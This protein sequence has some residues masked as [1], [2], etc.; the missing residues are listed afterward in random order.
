MLPAKIGPWP[1]VK[2]LSMGAVSEVYLVRDS[3]DP[4]VYRV[5]KRILP[6][7]TERLDL[8]EAF[9]REARLSRAFNHPNLVPIHASDMDCDAPYVVMEFVE[10]C[11]L[12]Q[13]MSNREGA[14]P[15]EIAVRVACDVAE[16]LEH[17]HGLRDEAGARLVVA[18]RDVTPRN[19]MLPRTGEAVLIDFGLVTGAIAKRMTATD[20]VKGTWRYAAPEQLKGQDVGP[21]TDVYGLAA[22]FSY[23][24]TGARPFSDCSGLDEM[25]ERKQ[26]DP[27]RARGLPE[28]VADVVERAT[29]VDPRARYA[30][31]SEFQTS[32][33]AVVKPA[34]SS[35]VRELLGAEIEVL[36]QKVL[37]PAKGIP[38]RSAE[39]LGEE[40]TNPRTTEDITQVEFPQA[41]D[42]DA[43]PI[44]IPI[45]ALILL[46][47]FGVWST[48]VF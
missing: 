23:L 24:A 22:I 12:L 42:D 43:P 47:I 45:S 11:S 19:I 14:L 6:V 31:V 20:V 5:I 30:S 48:V 17:L 21:W 39:Q 26:S 32:L 41:T 27:V 40:V 7:L 46:L 38:L 15:L 25:L 9:E 28:E 10:G 37:E 13:L 29:R 16:G 1:V 36:V 33:R 2:K 44:I 4:D 3:D 35:D 34:S 8:V 18:H